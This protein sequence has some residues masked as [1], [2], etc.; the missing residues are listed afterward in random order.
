MSN[1]SSSLPARKAK[2]DRIPL[3][4]HPSGRWCKKYRGR[5]HYFG[6][7]LQSALVKYAEEW[8]YISTGQPVPIKGGLTVRDLCNAFLTYKKGLLETGEL[9]T[10]TWRDYHAVCEGFIAH[11]GKE[12]SVES[13]T[14]TDLDGLR[15][16]AAKRLGPQA[17]GVY[18]DKV[19]G[20]L[21]FAFDHCLIDRPV[22]LGSSLKGPGRR[23]LLQAK[24][25]QGP[26]MYEPE[27]VKALLGAGDSVTRAWVLLGVNAGLGPMDL[28]ELRVEHLDLDGGWLDMARRK[29]GIMR[30]IPLW[31][32]TIAA[33][34]AA[35]EVRPAPR[36][37]QYAD[38]VFLTSRGRALKAGAG[39]AVS[40]RWA[41]LCEAAGVPNRGHYCLRHVFRTIADEVRDAPA[42]DLVMG[43]TDAGMASYYRERIADARL[44]RV[45]EHV[46]E[47][48]FG[49]QPAVIPFERAV[50]GQ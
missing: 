40:P 27:Q 41:A 6:T 24:Q 28:S 39:D 47:W 44:L 34:R 1:S 29:T 23:V 35:L 16:A 15:A 49:S 43:H 32:E 14:P 46:R 33:I 3:W 10:F 38:R 20:V 8:P 45:T 26:R 22:R 11:F 12:R 7:D 25:A 4:R 9:T 19:R 36:E 37:R 18:L 30:R 42:I 31:S 2:A 50:E 17:L 13:L 5:F 21:K 48:L